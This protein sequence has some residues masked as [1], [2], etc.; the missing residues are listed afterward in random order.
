MTRTY[1]DHCGKW[2]GIRVSLHSYAL[3][4]GHSVHATWMSIQDRPTQADWPQLLHCESPL[5]CYNVVL[6]NLI[7]SFT[8]LTLVTSLSLQVLRW[9]ASEMRYKRRAS[10]W[11]HWARRSCSS[12]I[13]STRL[14]CRSTSRQSAAVTNWTCL[15]T[16]ITSVALLPRPVL[17]IVFLIY[18]QEWNLTIVSIVCFL[19]SVLIIL[20]DTIIV[21]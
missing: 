4:V 13:P 5:K 11:Q 2:I 18:E 12:V 6:V 17:A 3:S 1:P 21:E 19:C 8:P 15:N 14:E 10:R 9:R 20:K 16:G 7:S